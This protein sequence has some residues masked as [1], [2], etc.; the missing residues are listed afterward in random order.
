MHAA[1]KRN[2]T[3]KAIRTPFFIIAFVLAQCP[4][5]GV[6]RFNGIWVLNAEKSDLGGS[7]ALG[8]LI[9]RAEETGG[10][11]TICRISS[12][13]GGQH[14]T[15]REYNLDPAA[16]LSNGVVVSTP[17][18]L[19]LRIDSPAGMR[20]DEEWHVTPDGKLIIVRVVTESSGAVRQRLVLDPGVPV[21]EMPGE[22]R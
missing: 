14:I 15:R 8:R 11:L 4:G 13:S 20:I 16:A 1:W 9:V 18:R 2:K 7:S 3:M 6:S 17:V 5:Y 12:D 19:V 21:T 10:R 22:R